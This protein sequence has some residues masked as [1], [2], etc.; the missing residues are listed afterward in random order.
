MKL[1]VTSR[2]GEKKSDVKKIR[3]EGNIPGI[4]YAPGKTPEKIIVNGS[5]YGALMRKVKSG[6]LPTTVF[7]LVAGNKQQK[8]IVKEVQYEI[9]RYEVSHLDFEE[10]NDDVLVKI[11]VPITITGAVD[12][13]GV[14]LGGT[15]RQV[16][17]FVEVECL[18]K[19]IP[20]EFVVDVKD[21]GIGQVKRLADLKV[22][23][24][25]RPLAKETEVLIVVAKV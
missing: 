22:P 13:V 10:L 19:H 7:T 11:K 21:L 18:P 3:R 8:A 25:V 14:K 23:E 20:S 5:E 2:T 4:V 15:L 6:Q 1:T 9:T 12:C 17:R 16:V 24:K